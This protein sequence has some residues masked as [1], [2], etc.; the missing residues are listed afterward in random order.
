MYDLFMELDRQESLRFEE[1]YRFR[2]SMFRSVLDI[3]GN[4]LLE[5]KIKVSLPIV[6]LDIF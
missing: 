6:L 4:L 2:I 1:S 5:V 3:D